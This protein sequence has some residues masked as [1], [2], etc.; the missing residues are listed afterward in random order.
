MSVL[1]TSDEARRTARR[2]MRPAVL[3]VVL[4][5]LAAGAATSE[6]GVVWDT[7]D[8]LEPNVK[9]VRDVA[10]TAVD[11]AIAASQSGNCVDFPTMP[12]T[13][14]CRVAEARGTV[15][16]MLDSPSGLVPPV[17]ET[18]PPSATC[19]VA[20]G[21]AAVCTSGSGSDAEGRTYYKGSG[22]PKWHCEHQENDVPSTNWRVPRTVRNSYRFCK[23]MQGRIYSW[24]RDQRYEDCPDTCRQ[25]SGPEDTLVD[26]SFSARYR[27]NVCEKVSGYGLVRCAYDWVSG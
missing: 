4:M 11:A 15:D 20:D 27:R 14:D 3:L 13:R 23:A 21:R 5:A 16:G 22:P 8:Q 6:A 19:A 10:G 25:V 26:K 1:R 17:A 2:P 24:Y 7:Y 12:P 18:G 9:P